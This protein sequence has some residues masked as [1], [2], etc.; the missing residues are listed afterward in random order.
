MKFLSYPL[1]LF[2][3]VVSIYFLGLFTESVEGRQYER[4]LLA[5]ASAA[6]APATGTLSPADLLMR[7]KLYTYAEKLKAKEA[8]KTMKAEK[9]TAKDAAFRAY[10][11][12]AFA[13][14][15]APAPVAVDAPASLS[16]MDLWKK[17]VA[18]AALKQP[19]STPAATTEDP[20]NPEADS[21]DAEDDKA[22]NEIVKRYAPMLRE[23]FYGNPHQKYN[24]KNSKSDDHHSKRKHHGKSEENEEDYSD[25]STGLTPNYRSGA[26]NKYGTGPAGSPNGVGYEDAKVNQAGC[27][28]S[29]IGI[30]SGTTVYLTN[31]DEA[32]ALIPTDYAHNQISIATDVDEEI[33]DEEQAQEEQEPKEDEKPK[34]S[35]KHGKKHGHKKGH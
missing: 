1:V 28:G 30:C 23:K 15:P 24:H 29:N 35:S 21:D 16:I 25:E 34:H 4:Q 12:A 18:A 22:I 5:P 6:A 33:R 27:S 31:P 19:T 2:S 17:A 10:L 13:A 9:K 14:T 32:G 26:F 20:E 7:L 8:K 11:T 3:I